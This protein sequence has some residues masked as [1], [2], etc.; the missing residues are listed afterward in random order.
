MLC[1]GTV[2]PL[3]KRFEFRFE[4]LNNASLGVIKK[5]FEASLCSWMHSTVVEIKKCIKKKQKSKDLFCAQFQ[6]VKGKINAILWNEQVPENYTVIFFELQTLL[7]FDLFQQEQNW[8]C[9]DSV[10]MLP[11][12]DL[13]IC[14]K[15]KQIYSPSW[16]YNKIKTSLD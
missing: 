12:L 4:R 7:S 10:E 2:K 9:V 11:I 13:K 1:T 15:N 16:C 5:C 14:Y 6:R 8:S 3:V